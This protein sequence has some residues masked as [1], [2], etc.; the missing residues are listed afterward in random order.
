L[1]SPVPYI[2]IDELDIALHKRAV[3][4]YHGAWSGP[5]VRVY[6]LLQQK[7]GSLKDPPALL[8]LDADDFIKC[9]DGQRRKL[10]QLFG[11]ETGGFGE[12]CWIKD[13]HVMAQDIL[14]KL[15]TEQVLEQRLKELYS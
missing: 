11:P 7:L 14:A 2:K 10:Q 9:T 4:Y 6:R 1:S 13:G 12:T 3:V 5:S 8:V 15:Q